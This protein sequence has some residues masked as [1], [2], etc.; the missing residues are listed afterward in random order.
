ME[1][2]KRK[3]ESEDQTKTPLEEH[4]EVFADH[5][6]NYQ[7]MVKDS[8]KEAKKSDRPVHQKGLQDAVDNLKAEIKKMKDHHQTMKDDAKKER[9]AFNKVLEH[10]ENVAKAEKHVKHRKT[11]TK[12]SKSSSPAE[13]NFIELAKRKGKVVLKNGVYT[14]RKKSKGVV[15]TMKSHSSSAIGATDMAASCTQSFFEGI[16]PSFCWK[17]G[18]DVGVIP[19]GCPN[20]YFRHLALCFQ[21]CPKGYSFDGASLCR[22]DCPGDCTCFPLTCTHFDWRVWKDWTV[23]RDAF[24]T[25]SITNFDS[26][27]TCG[28]NMYK[29]GALC[30]RDCKKVGLVN[31]GIGMC[32][33]T[34]EACASGIGN[35]VAN[36]LTSLAKGVGFI[37][38][39][40]TDS[41]A[42]ETVGEVKTGLSKLASTA[43]KAIEDGAA[44]VKR[45]ASDPAVRKEFVD[46]LI[47]IA[48]NKL[49]SKIED[50]IQ[51]QLIETVCG[52]LGNALLDKAQQKSSFDISKL[53]VL[54]IGNIKDSCTN[55]P[56]SNG[57][58]ACAQ[59]ILNT[60]DNVDPTGLAGMAAAFMQPVCDV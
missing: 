37:L 27:I 22:K 44:T 52:H 30:Y 19:T 18:A 20:G 23:S 6:Q 17:K 50:T 45:I 42:A 59:S 56:D 33:A 9:K 53:D 54:G 46:K 21:N 31:C 26:S 43:T 49:K 15:S 60:V 5:I 32:A 25:H 38:S 36:F 4:V 39:F 57:G 24:F 8:S 28:A 58:I 14:W 55:I 16:P 1:R 13:A 3:S 40:G 51:T 7:K 35:M 41:A 48:K 12:P 34:G 11:S 29:S 10:R 47:G 2:R